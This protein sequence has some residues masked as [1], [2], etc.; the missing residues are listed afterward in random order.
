MA[1]SRK[2]NCRIC[3]LSDGHTLINCPNKCSFCGDLITRCQCLD[4]SVVRGV[5]DTE[6]PEKK[7]ADKA[8]STSKRNAEAVDLDDR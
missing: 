2:K 1:A 4:S 5:L 6:T 8:P 3:G 7:S